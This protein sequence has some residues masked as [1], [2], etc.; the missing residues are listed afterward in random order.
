MKIIG[1]TGP[2]GS[3]KTLFGEYF[4]TLGIPVIN[5]DEV[6]HKMLIPPSECL[7]AIKQAFGSSVISDDG[8]LD[9]AALSSIVFHDEKK[10]A[11][12]NKTVLGIVIKEIRRQVSELEQNN[13]VTVMIDAP[14]LIESGLYKD[15]DKIISIISSKER[16][17]VRIAQ[18]DGIDCTKAQERVEAQQPDEFYIKYSDIVLENDGSEEDFIFKLKKLTEEI[19]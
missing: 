5:A 18:R 12:L 19:L 3:G 13:N 10:L 15:C 16:R 9:R 7:D 8:A 4:S 2:S 11:L 14:T 6:Y 1:V 17:I